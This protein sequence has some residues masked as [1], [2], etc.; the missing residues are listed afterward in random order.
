VSS[1]PIVVATMLYRMT[2][3]KSAFGA[4]HS[5]DQIEL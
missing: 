3:V 2:F 4:F 5:P 1:E